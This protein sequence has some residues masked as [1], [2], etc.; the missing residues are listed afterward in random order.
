MIDVP[1]MG[2]GLSDLGDALFRIGEAELDKEQAA[3][4]ADVEIAVANEISALLY[5]PEAGYLNTRRSNAVKGYD[6]FSEAI[7]KVKDKHFKDLPSGVATR[8]DA[9]VESR[10]MRAREQA[11]VH[12]ADER[13]AW[14]DESASALVDLAQRETITNAYSDAEVQEGL[15]MM[16]SNLEALAVQKGWSKEQF[17]LELDKR[18]AD[19]YR[20]VVL[21]RAVDDP[22]AALAYARTHEDDLGPYMADIERT[23]E[24]MAK[25]RIGRSTVARW[26]NGTQPVTLTGKKNE[27]FVAAD[28]MNPDIDGIAPEVLG[29]FS[30]LQGE[31]GE[32]LKINSGHRDEARNEAAGGAKGSQHIHGKAIDIDVSGMRTED[33]IR[34]IETASALGFTG[35]G[36]YDNAIHIDTGP[37]RVWGPRRGKKPGET[38]DG[39][40][41]NWAFAT[42]Q[43]HMAGKPSVQGMYDAALKIPDEDVQRA[44]LAEI[45]TRTAIQGKQ[46]QLA[47]QQAQDDLWAKVSAGEDPTKIPGVA[48]AVGFQFYRAMETYHR[49][50]AKG[51][52]VVT[53]FAVYRDLL[54]MMNERPE[55]FYDTQLTNLNA[56]V[57]DISL[58]DLKTLQEVQAAGP[59]TSAEMAYSTKLAPAEPV[60]EGMG[61]V[62]GKPGTDQAKAYAQMEVM[63]Q[64]GVDEFI[65]REKRNPSQPEM[66]MIALDAAMGS[67]YFTSGQHGPILDKVK[68]STLAAAA[69][70]HTNVAFGT[71]ASRDDVGLLEFS[72]AH[73]AAA[74]QW[75]AAMGREPS[76]AEQT[77]IAENIIEKFTIKGSG[78]WYEWSDDEI[79]VYEL[80]NEAMA[81]IV[82]NG[83]TLVDEDGD[84][85]EITDPAALLRR[86]RTGIVDLSNLGFR[87]IN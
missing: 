7:A 28:G 75:T 53:N 46:K 24:P 27:T 31:F 1:D 22:V 48:Q 55:E 43:G 47:Q 50:R 23:L 84:E 52:N 54:I 25:E 70:N 40:I 83:Y 29:M 71:G 63:Y 20:H 80:T 79:R 57:N 41:P 72:K 45:E 30:N 9:A 33:R 4:A 2:A 87:K 61:Y 44:A 38:I 39:S 14:H 59:K 65:A 32:T 69:K 58:S 3:E 74:E 34:L 12:L 37:R 21:S 18:T 16:S 73:M 11:G 67:Q 51:V 8:V 36:V 49:N 78:A 60:W 81:T 62:D 35:I 10:L 15:A 26:F 13:T 5:D 17:V 68:V 85:Y 86:A 66:R 6:G 76:S 77:T 64:R 19:V 42:M 82:K 56:Y